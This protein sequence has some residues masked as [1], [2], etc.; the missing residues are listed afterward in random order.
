MPP[1]LSPSP[2]P[3]RPPPHRAAE[4]WVWGW[5][6]GAAGLCWGQRR[7]EHGFG[8]ALLCA[9]CP[10]WFQQAS[11]CCGFEQI[12]GFIFNVFSFIFF[13]VRCSP[14]HLVSFWE[15][16]MR[17]DRLSPSLPVPRLLIHPSTHPSIFCFHSHTGFG[18]HLC[19]AW[20]SFSLLTAFSS[21][22]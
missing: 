20:A 7:A 17:G 6:L 11:Q 19:R 13:F 9:S 12:S 21:Q 14:V 2:S 22:Q 18:P 16:Q 4:G 1:S 10:R 3:H 5:A 15:G 8:D